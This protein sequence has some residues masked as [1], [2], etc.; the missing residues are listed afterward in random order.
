MFLNLFGKK[1]KKGDAANVDYF[2]NKVQKP[3]D[4]SID[5][6]FR[7]GAILIVV[8]ILYNTYQA[9]NQVATQPAEKQASQSAEGQIEVKVQEAF[10]KMKKTKE[11]K[12]ISKFVNMVESQAGSGDASVLEAAGGYV[13]F[14]PKNFVDDAK[15][16][17]NGIKISSGVVNFNVKPMLK[18][19]SPKVKS[20]EDV[21]NVP[22]SAKKA[23]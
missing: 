6:I 22:D 21:K 16:Q 18:N 23:Q 4:P 9:E 7:I 1:P 19:N 5:K 2:G 13:I 12:K 20:G 8:Y 15:N 14:I 3:I 10:E 17:K 11:F